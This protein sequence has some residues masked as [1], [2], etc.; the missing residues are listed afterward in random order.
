MFHIFTV[1]LAIL[2]PHSLN[3]GFNTFLFI[4]FN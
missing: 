4:Q 3:H 1:Y 2:R